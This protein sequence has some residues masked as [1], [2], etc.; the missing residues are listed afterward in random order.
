MA[1]RS[2]AASGSGSAGADDCHVHLFGFVQFGLR[3]RTEQG[4]EQPLMEAFGLVRGV[5]QDRILAN[6]RLAEVVAMAA[7]R[8]DQRVVA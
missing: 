2:S 7:D 3:L 1:E 8:D 6:T 4:I 5:Q